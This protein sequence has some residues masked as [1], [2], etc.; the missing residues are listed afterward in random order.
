MK[1]AVNA[2]PAAVA[3][4]RASCFERLHLEAELVRDGLHALHDVAR[5]RSAGRAAAPVGDH[6]GADLARVPEEPLRRRERHQHRRVGGPGTLEAHDV[7]DAGRAARPTGVDDHP[8]TGDDAKLP[9]GLP[10]QVDLAGA[11]LREREPRASRADNPRETVHPGRIGGEE[12]DARLALPL[13]RSLHCNLLHDR[14]GDAVDEPRSGHRRFDAGDGALRE[15]AHAGCGAKRTRDVVDR[16]P[17]C[18]GLVGRAEC[19]DGG[20]ADR[21]VHRVAGC[22]RGGDDHRAQHQP[23]HDQGAAAT[24]AADVPN[25]QLE[26]DRVSNSQNRH[27]REGDAQRDR[28]DRQQCVDRDPEELLHGRP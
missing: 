28:Q 15:P 26:Q 1:N 9:G 19:L 17:R 21:I 6:H 24:S 22:Q 3:S 25:G 8:V 14:A 10:V 4:S 16:A 13:N 18:D 7:A 11:Q 2:A 20:R 23:D 12:H 27:D 5:E